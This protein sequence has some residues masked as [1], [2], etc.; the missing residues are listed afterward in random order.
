MLLSEKAPKP[1]MVK[2]VQIDELDHEGK[3]IVFPKEG[4]VDKITFVA[5]AISGEIC[6]I[7]QISAS[8]GVQQAEV[9]KVIQ[10]SEHRRTPF[11]PH[12]Q[13]CGGCQTQH[14]D[15]DWLRIKKQ[16]A[17]EASLQKA[18]GLNIVHIPWQKPLVFSPVGYRRKSRLAIDARNDDDLKMGFRNQKNEVFN[19]IECQVLE[20]A[21]QALVQ[22]LKVL[23]S[24]L[25][26]KKVLGHMQLFQ[27]DSVVLSLRFTKDVTEFDR[28]LLRS[29]S[30]QY[31]CEVQLELND[32]KIVSL[33]GSAAAK[34]TYKLGLATQS[35]LEIAVASNDFVQVNNKINQQMVQ[36]AIDWLELK[37][38]DRVLDLFCG[39]GNFSLPL[40]QQCEQVVGFEGVPEMV[41]NAQANAQLNGISNVSFVSGDLTDEK[42][43]A[44]L[45]KQNCNKVLLDPARAG[46]LKAVET[47]LDMLPEK[48]LYVSCNPATFGRDIAKLLNPEQKNNNRVIKK[49][50]MNKKGD[51]RQS[52]KNGKSNYQLVKLSLVDMFP[53][54]SHSEIMGLFRS[55]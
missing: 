44:E 35:E 29:F 53:N 31:D 16:E 1:Q 40:A 11:C 38:N 39:V 25:R 37:P 27:G 9:R 10:A 17:I 49:H 14:I 33:D 30:A 51:N 41:Q 13:E 2:S 4:A 54:T 22:P 32:K 23:V 42:V 20:P 46:A 6:D 18:A 21:L 48:I 55:C 5:G 36:Q 52:S 45:R 43:L 8:K 47:L 26:G 19:L 28:E 7:H 3:G 34:A 50:A 15:Q 24:E 12:F